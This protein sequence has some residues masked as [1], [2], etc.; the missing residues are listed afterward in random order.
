[1]CNVQRSF[2][3]IN[4]SFK[5]S[6]SYPFMVVLSTSFLVILLFEVETIFEIKLLGQ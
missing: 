5:V 6:S 4:L 3:F 1:M 2:V